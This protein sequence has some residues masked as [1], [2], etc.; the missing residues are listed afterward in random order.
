[1]LR[2]PPV[3]PLPHGANDMARE[4]RV[5]SS[6]WRE[7]PLAPRAVLFCDDASVLGAP[8]QLLEYRPGIVIRDA[9]PPDLVG[10]SEVGVLLSRQ[11]V[12]VSPPCMPSIRSRSAWRRSAPAG[13]LARTVEGWA[14]RAAAVA[15]LIKSRVR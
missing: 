14:A 11:L 12:E 7:Y 4:Y 1:M 2:R 13:F 15:D 10:R 3:G 6:L 5:L 8:F 9:L